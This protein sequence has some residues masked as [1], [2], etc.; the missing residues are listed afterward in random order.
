LFDLTINDR[1]LHCSDA[2]IGH[3]VS[4]KSRGPR[5]VV[6]V[7]IGFNKTKTDI[8]SKV[9]QAA[10]Q[11]EASNFFQE[12]Y[13]LQAKTIHGPFRP[14]RAQVLENTRTLKFSDQKQ[15]KAIYREWEVSALILNEPADHAYLLFIRRLDGKKQPSP[16]GTVVVPISDL[17]IPNDEKTDAQN[18]ESPIN[19]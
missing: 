17:R 14:K 1:S 8:V 9:I 18:L 2:K 4:R 12:Q 16:K 11:E 5:P 10:S 7:V 6:F 15:I 13:G 3:F 19:G